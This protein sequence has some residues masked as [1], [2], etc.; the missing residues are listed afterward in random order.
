MSEPGGEQVAVEHLRDPQ[1][2]GWALCGVPMPA[3]P[4]GVVRVHE[5]CWREWELRRGEFYVKRD[6]E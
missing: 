1:R 4:C 3:D 2:P 5:V 6:Y